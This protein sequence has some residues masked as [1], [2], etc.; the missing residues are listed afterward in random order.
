LVSYYVYDVAGLYTLDWLN[1]L[2]LPEPERILNINA[3]FDETSSLLKAKYPDASLLV[4]DFYDPT[5]HTEVSIKRARQAYPPYPGTQQATTHSLPL[6]DEQLDLIFIILAAHEIRVTEERILFF[7]ELRRCLRPGGKIVVV[8]HQRDWPNFLA[9]NIG[10]LHFLSP[11]SWQHTFD[12]A[13]LEVD[14]QLKITS[15]ISVYS[16]K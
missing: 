14:Q 15:F 10:F 6:A 7:R 11:Q 12:H 3:G 9:Y 13:Q 8:E 2:N 1:H 5:L 16:L 4:F